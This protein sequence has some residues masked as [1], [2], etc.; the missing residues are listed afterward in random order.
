MPW[1]SPA[2][3]AARHAPAHPRVASMVCNVPRRSELEPFE[4]RRIRG[5]SRVLPQRHDRAIA[6]LDDMVVVLPVLASVPGAIEFHLD[7]GAIVLDD[8]AHEVH[9]EM[10]GLRGRPPAA[11]SWAFMNKLRGTSPAPAI[12]HVASGWSSAS[13]S[14][15]PLTSTRTAPAPLRRDASNNASVT[16]LVSSVVLVMDH[17]IAPLSTGASTRE[18]GADAFELGSLPLD[19]AA[20]P[21]G[22]VRLPIPASGSPR[23][24]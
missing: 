5:V 6:H 24:S 12:H 2:N 18:R 9:P 17:S 1:R 16:A 11:N 22:L 14:C 15:A 8:K 13:I 10:G 21:R 4:R 23:R 19:H 7:G 3:R 20:D